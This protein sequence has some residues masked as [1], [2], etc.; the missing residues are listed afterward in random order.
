MKIMVRTLKG[1]LTPVEVTPELTVKEL[2]DIMQAQK[3]INQEDQKIIFKGKCLNNPD[4][5]SAIG[6]KENDILGILTQIKKKKEETPVPET[7]KIETSPNQ[8]KNT[9][10]PTEGKTEN[11]TTVQPTEQPKQEEASKEGS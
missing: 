4:T 2:K 5:M 1:E 8:N 3:G 11:K 6:V 10:K 9:E 7:N